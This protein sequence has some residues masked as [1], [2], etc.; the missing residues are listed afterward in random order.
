MSRTFPHPLFQPGRKSGAGTLFA[1]LLM[2][3]AWSGLTSAQA[4]PHSALPSVAFYYG[5]NPPINALQGF[6][7]IVVDGNARLP[8]PVSGL[9]PGQHGS[10][11]FAYVSIGEVAE[12]AA[13]ARQPP[14][15]CVIG[16]NRVWKARILDLRSAICRDWLVDKRFAPLIARGFHD[17][18]LDTLDSYQLALTSPQ[19]QRAYQQGIVALI[20]RVHARLPQAGFILNRGF[21]LLDALKGKGVLGVAAESLYR[22]WDEAHK[23][24]VGVKPEDTLWLKQQ[25]ERVRSRG[26]VPI[27]ID[28]VAHDQPAMAT[29]TA[30]RIVADG[31]VPYVTNGQLNRVGVGKGIAQPREILMLYDDADSPMDTNVNWYAAMVLNH[32]GYATRAMNVDTQALPAVPMRG[33]IAGVVTW[34]SGPGLKH[35]ER[36]YQWL[37]RQMK[38]GVPVAILGEFGFSAD[39]GHLSALGIGLGADP[40]PG[41]KTVSVSSSDASLTGFENPARASPGNFIP[42]A[43]QQGRS[44][45]TVARD[46]QQE[47]AVA[48]TPW[49]GYALSPYVL[50]N[51]PRGTLDKNQS[52]ARWILNPFTFFRQAL[53][54][55]TLPA[56]DTTTASGN[57]LLFAHFDGDGFA[58]GSY[59]AAYRSQPA[60]KVILDAILQRYHIPTAASV[61]ASEFVD[62]GLYRPKQLAIYRPIA[63]AM[64]ALPWVEIGSHTYSHPFD[65]SAL[66]HDPRLSA[67]LHLKTPGAAAKGS[68]AYVTEPNLRYGYNLPVPG[69]TFSPQQEVD[70]SV[71][72]INT[73]LAPAGKKVTLFQWSGDTN[74]D[75]EVV[76]L[77]YQA[78]LANINGN[79]STIDEA[80][81]SLT[82]VVGL[83]VW[84]GRY[85]QVYAP[86]ANEDQFTDGWKPPYCGYRRVIQTF[87]LTESPRRLAP[88]NIYY[89]LYSGARPCALDALKSVYDWALK[90]PTTPVFPSYYSKIALGFEY[91]GIA[92]DGNAYLLGGYG[93]DQTVRIPRK[94]GYPDLARSHNVAGFN[95]A[96]Q[97]RYISLGPDRARLV[98]ADKPPTEPYLVSA[99]AV[100]HALDRSPGKL[101][102]SFA[103]QV[104]LRVT[105]AQSQGCRIRFQG[106]RAKVTARGRLRQFNSSLDSGRL[107]V[108]CPTGSVVAP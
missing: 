82:N 4:A 79:N 94:L 78:G 1:V 99:N 49:G 15:A 81:P 17:F 9:G 93:A 65:W 61:I 92:R 48:I 56:F 73:L 85:F 26:L 66:E 46:G 60:A 52:R 38:S 83:G 105:L 43:L 12:S 70:G 98:L 33:R 3:C 24:Y 7:W 64:F 80:S 62:G 14:T 50:A 106:H 53:R 95:D 55:D 5:Q 89:H 101:S 47:A 10:T 37:R 16:K 102:L 41:L 18:F 44:A 45:L 58:S 29:Q 11:Y 104:P 21:E 57:R 74:P 91:A 86:D 90:Q 108:A 42:L 36:V 100:I 35:G 34:F 27:A 76:G 59:I 22:G 72:I 13:A 107:E 25:L 2:V 75:A 77:V 71:T 51:L 32:M 68:D 20:D 84:K 67:G 19:Q 63:R 28:Y 103:G 39:A 96:N 8:T 54:L 88:I 97:S 69:Y 31:F 40:A 87:R 6:D 30:R 23:R